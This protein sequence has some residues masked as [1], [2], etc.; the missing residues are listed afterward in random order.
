[1]RLEGLTKVPGPIA[2][3]LRNR[4]QQTKRRK[5]RFHVLLH[6]IS[7]HYDLSGSAR[8]GDFPGRPGNSHTDILAPTMRKSMNRQVIFASTWVP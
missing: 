3:E 2:A 8:L 4:A 5:P 6:G 1:M 7:S